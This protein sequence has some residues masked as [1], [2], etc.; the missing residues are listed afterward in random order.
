MILTTSLAF[1]A[2]TLAADSLPESIRLPY[3]HP[4]L[5]VDLGVGLWASPFPMDF[6]GDGD[7]DL[8]V[9]CADT[10]SNGIY[11]FE[12]PGGSDTPV[13]K[14]GVRIGEA[15]HNTT[16]SYTGGK[17]IM[18]RPKEVYPDFGPDGWGKR[19]KIDFVFKEDLGKTRANQWKFA[20]YDGNG[21]RDLVLGI[22]V[23][24][25]YGWDDAWNERGEWQNGPLHGYV[26]VVPN[27]GTN[28]AP[29]YGEPFRVQAGGSDVDTYGCPS[30]NFAD[31]D[32]D[33][34]LDLLTG[35]FLDRL[36]YFEN[37][38]TRSEPVYAAGRFIQQDRKTL[39]LDLQM[40]QVVAFDWNQDGHTD[41][42][43]GKEDGRVVYL[44]HTGWQQGGVPLFDPPV[45]FQQEAVHVKTGA[46][47][48][49]YGIDWDG[50]GDDDI[51]SG[52]TAGYLNFVENLGGDP[53]QWAAPVYLKADGETIRIQ[54]GPNG[55]IQGP[56]EA[57]W[58]YTVLNAADWNHDGLPDLVINSIWGRV[59]WFENIG[60]RT[61]PKLKAA[62]PIE[63]EWKGKTP[64]P[65]WTWWKPKGDELVTQWRTTPIVYDWNGD[66]LNDL[67]MLDT[68]GY[69]S[70]YERAKKRRKLVLLPPQR[71]FLDEAG[72]P[73]R[74]NERT[75][76]GS[77]RRKIAVTDWDGDG[78]PDLLLNSSSADWMRCV[79]A[80]GGT[81]R[82]AAPQLLDGRKVAGHTSC[83][84]TVDWDQNGIPDLLV[85][86]EDG[87][88]YYLKNPRS[89]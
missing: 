14:P 55:S 56:A 33:G 73:L 81:W 62:Q 16:I 36:T 10:P 37:T 51:L 3:N 25:D 6:D 46:L 54:A 32:N 67:A 17:P 63:V 41:V 61:E 20:D 50:D 15:V 2:A 58:G 86:A 88:F 76:G 42:I 1:V 9:A 59:E 66:G 21:A 77:G 23:W 39:H 53:P 52:D 40:L 84:A 12:N 29:E 74:L 79:S 82:F 18:A 44:R 72:Q 71:V 70:L 83:P 45:Y 60:T 49:P 24:A 26:Y 43:V 8:L 78:L 89:K 87:F 38:G 57:K 48:T 47:S 34:D 80:E 13:F 31:F 64:K 7:P 85:G 19:E 5:V 35:E 65:A 4:G 69:F 28:D 68:E 75:A 30:P 22:G 27:T 11:F